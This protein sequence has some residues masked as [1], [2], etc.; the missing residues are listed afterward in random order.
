MVNI[1]L[2][3]ANGE[4]MIYK[5]CNEY[6]VMFGSAEGRYPEFDPFST[7]KKAYSTLC[8]P[9]IISSITNNKGK[10]LVGKDSVKI[11]KRKKKRP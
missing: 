2:S 1:R 6:D 5:E 3:P 8:K 4:N 7:R 10:T 11:Y 9:G